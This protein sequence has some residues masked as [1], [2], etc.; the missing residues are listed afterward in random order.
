MLETF[1][2]RWWLYVLV[3]VPFL[4][5]G[6]VTI[7][8]SKTTYRATGSVQVNRPAAVPDDPFGNDTP[9]IYTTRQI[10]TV[11]R[12]DKFLDALIDQAQLRTPVGSDPAIVRQ[13]VRQSVSAVPS[14]DDLVTISATNA[15]PDVAQS[16]ANSM[17]PAYVRFQID[18]A[19]ETRNTARD[20]EVLKESRYAQLTAQ[21]PSGSSQETA[22]AKLD[23]DDAQ[24]AFDKAQAAL[25]KQTQL[26]PQRFT[27]IDTAARPSAPEPHRRQDII[28]LV[29]FFLLG[30]MVMTAAVVVATLLD[31]SVR[32]SDEIETQLHVP[33]LA[34]VPDS[35]T[36]I[37]P[38]VL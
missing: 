23:M 18:N 8:N 14:G 37:E 30:V 20:D 11:L 3:L 36:A 33:V 21:D 38:L 22:Q 13:Q 12:T 24:F 1:F 26:M 5:L 6:V 29:L 32:Y 28:T 25:S 15:D 34:I 16:L 35:R 19:R 27:D 31:H 10:G 2:R 7:G 17:I 4:A 9:A